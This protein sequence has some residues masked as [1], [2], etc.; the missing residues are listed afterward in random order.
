MNALLRISNIFVSVAL[1][2]SGCTALPS[3]SEQRE[4]VTPKIA[5][6]ESILGKSLSDEA[7]A[8]FIL[9]NDCS[10]ADQFLLCSAAGIAFWTDSDEVE[11]VYLY[12]NNIDD[13][14]P[15]KGELPFG[16]KF[17]DNMAAVEYKLNRQ[18]FG[19]EGLPDSVSIPDRV[20]Y[21]A[22]YHQAGLTIL[23]NSPFPDEDAS[24]YAILLSSQD[25]RAKDQ[26]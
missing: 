11:T 16:L 2:I 1:L 14:V 15:Y 13:F 23:Y 26:P 17:Y 20:H 10:S 4:G 8:E 9:S 24:I 7:V 12:L 22:T 19:N 18:G 25:A 5:V 21:R 3:Q 6:Y